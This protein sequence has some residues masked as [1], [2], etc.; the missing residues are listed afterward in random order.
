MT[1]FEYIAVAWIINV[2]LNALIAEKPKPICYVQE[3][4]AEKETYVP[5]FCEDL[6]GKAK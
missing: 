1:P 5:R 3:F 4:I 6:E 2:S